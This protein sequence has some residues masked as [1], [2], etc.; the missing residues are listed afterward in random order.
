MAVMR[1]QFNALSLGVGLALACFESSTA[2]EG[3]QTDETVYKF[4][5]WT[6]GYNSSV[7]GCVASA[8]SLTTVPRFGLGLMV[9]IQIFLLTLHSPI[10]IGTP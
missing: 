6:I 5:S 2:R 3:L 8:I 1:R 9:R 4:E 7:K 10:R